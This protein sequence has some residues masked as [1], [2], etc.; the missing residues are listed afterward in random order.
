MKLSLQLYQEVQKPCIFF[1]GGDN[2]HVLKM[3]LL[4]DVKIAL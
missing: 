3:Q 4:C 1:E 2:Y